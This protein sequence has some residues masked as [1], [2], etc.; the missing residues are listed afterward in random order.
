MDREELYR[1][2]FFCIATQQWRDDVPRLNTNRFY[3]SICTI[4]DTMF[5]IGGNNSTKDLITIESINI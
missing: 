3:N 1:S 2:D 4:Q 5:T